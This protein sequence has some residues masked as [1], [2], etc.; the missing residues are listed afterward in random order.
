MSST[1]TEPYKSRLFNFFNRTSL[2]LRRRWANAG[3]QM[4]VAAAWGVQILLYPVYLLVQTGRV[5][6]HRLQESRRDDKTLPAADAPIQRVLE[7]VE[8]HMNATANEEKSGGLKFPFSLFLAPLAK[9]A[10]P[11]ATK[12]LDNQNCWLAQDNTLTEALIE[13]G[14]GQRDG[15]FK[16][17]RKPRKAAPP[18][19]RGKRIF[20]LLPSEAE[21]S[22][23]QGVA[24]LL[25]TRTL[26]LVTSDNRVLDLLTP[27]QQQILQQRISLEV[28]EYW[29]QPLPM[30]R[31]S[32]FPLQVF[33]KLMDWVQTS[34]VARAIDLFGES[35]LV[36][37]K[38]KLWERRI[39]PAGAIE[40]WGYWWSDRLTERL[41]ELT[42]GSPRLEPRPQP[43][44][45]NIQTLI[46]AGINYFLG[47]RR[48]QSF[49]EY[50]EG[51]EIPTSTPENPWLSWG[52]LFS[53]TPSPAG[54]Y[55]EASVCD[56]P[57]S[58]SA[59]Q[60]R[61]KRK[62][63]LLRAV[64]RVMGRVPVTPQNSHKSGSKDFTEGWDSGMPKAGENFSASFS[65]SSSAHTLPPPDWI[66]IEAIPIGYVKHPLERLL[67]WLDGIMLWLEELVRKIWRSLFRK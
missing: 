42:F 29:H 58:Q 17:S 16:L 59:P 33:W 56:L 49:Y 66:E 46:R 15:A 39:L 31:A 12:T 55:P 38:D 6:G 61:V 63:S 4:K 25:E 64:L 10:Q 13:Q 44:F 19:G 18:E 8:P 24:T 27:S 51:T 54:H 57:L 37:R 28:A 60:T 22:I 47:K 3:R 34:P 35:T 32:Y 48:R 53:L 52:D 65:P 1:S 67:V 21:A 2:H 9:R 20:N 50:A 7:T 43:D 11:Q 62:K 30:P 45:S 5:V 26:V 40:R 36:T 14:R 41:H 23:M